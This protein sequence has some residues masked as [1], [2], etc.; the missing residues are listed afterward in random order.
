[1]DPRHLLDLLVCIL[2]NG[3]KLGLSARRLTVASDACVQVQDVDDR[4]GREELLYP[5][6]EGV[7]SVLKQN[8]LLELDLRDQR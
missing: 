7:V 2:V 8:F 6:P 1:M 5:E 3:G 4:Q